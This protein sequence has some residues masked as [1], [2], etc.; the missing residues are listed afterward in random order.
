MEEQK[1][2][3]LKKLLRRRGE[4]HHKIVTSYL[5]GMAELEERARSCY[6]EYI[7]LDSD[8]FAEM[9]LFDACFIVG[10]FPNNRP[11]G[12]LYYKTKRP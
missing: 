4:D 10:L 5:M 9:I 12:E 7:S 2:R 8:Q 1:M 6:A 3:N 11:D